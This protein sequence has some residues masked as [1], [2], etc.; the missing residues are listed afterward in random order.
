MS[1]SLVPSNEEPELFQMNPVDFN[2]IAV[3][4]QDVKARIASA[5]GRAGRRIEDV[6]LLA[7][8]KFNPIESVMA[9]YHAGIKCF[10]ENRV[11]EA[12]A[13]YCAIQ[14]K[15]PDIE[16][17]LLGHLQGNKIKKALGVF[18]CIQSVDSENLVRDL[19]LRCIGA[20]TAMDVL[21]ELHTGEE[22]KSGFS[23]VD[24]LFRAIE[25]TSSLPGI[26]LR[27]LMTMAPFTEDPSA[28]R[29]SFRTCAE[30][31]RKAR[32]IFNGDDFTILSMGMT[33]DFEIA[34][35]EGSTMVRI[36]TAIFGKRA[37]I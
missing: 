10:G 17:H 4:V 36:G 22:S 23:N 19:S 15:Y 12:E 28:I 8:T 31:F 21:Y 7:V 16:L 26:N 35:E 11:Q 3:S 9:S 5:C 1:G 25:N 6:T 27:G 13:K 2:A 32:E 18:D 14:K 29:A 37:R 30:A 20:D 33:N 24:D 34:I